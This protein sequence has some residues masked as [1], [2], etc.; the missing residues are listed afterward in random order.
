MYMYI[1]SVKIKISKK[2]TFLN[3]FVV[4]QGSLSPKVPR[5]KDVV[6]PQ[7]YTQTHTKVNTED[8]LSG[9]HEF[10]LQP[11]IKDRSN[12]RIVEL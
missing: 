5:S 10:V 11:I 9:F 4:S 2:K 12:K 8:I 1:K 6:C 7:T 3:A